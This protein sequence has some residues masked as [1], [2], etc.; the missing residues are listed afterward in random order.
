MSPDVLQQWKKRLEAA[1]SRWSEACVR[2]RETAI[3]RLVLPRPDGYLA[4]KQALQDETE[5]LREYKRLLTE[6]ARLQNGG[7]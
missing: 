4:H 6:F 3:E 2:V 1:S 7:L 5:A